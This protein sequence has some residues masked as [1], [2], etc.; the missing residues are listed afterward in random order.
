MYGS[1]SAWSYEPCLCFTGYLGRV[2]GPV[3][4]KGPPQV[5]GVHP[6]PMWGARLWMRR[7]NATSRKNSDPVRTTRPL[8]ILQ[9]NAEG[10][11]NKKVLLTEP[12]HMEDV[13][14]ARKGIWQDYTFIARKLYSSLWDLLSTGTFI[15]ETGVSIWPKRRR[16]RRNTF[17]VS[18][19]AACMFFWVRLFP[20]VCWIFLDICINC[21]YFLL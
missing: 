21:K 2:P 12:L 3:P 10:I 4:Q 17:L 13:D 19:F 5:N 8:N 16:R 20:C 7:V 15:E 9:W 14:V 18:G 11:Y 1:L 6:V